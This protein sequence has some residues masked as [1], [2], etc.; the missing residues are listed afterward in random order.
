MD[1]NSRC[2]F[3]STK[4]VTKLDFTFHADLGA[5]PELLGK[6]M[7]VIRGMA[8]SAGKEFEIELS[9]REAIINAVVHGC[10]S[11]SSKIVQCW[12]GC[13]E[14]RGLLIVVRDP[15][16]GFDPSALPDPL[17]GKNL[18]AS[19]G[20]GIFLINQLMDEVTFKNGGTEIHMLKR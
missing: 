9:L 7:E 1:T 3:D 20:R 6:I 11:D 17:V 15:G 12:V 4:L 19:H 14:S 2:E 8:C 13:D 18:Y 5:V 10:R 16:K